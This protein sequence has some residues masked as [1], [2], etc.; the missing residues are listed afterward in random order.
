MFHR[1]HVLRISEGN[2]CFVLPYS[3]SCNNRIIEASQEREEERE[4][5][6]EREGG[7][8]AE[9][10]HLDDWFLT[11]VREDRAAVSFLSDVLC[12]RP[13]FHAPVALGDPQSP[14]PL[15]PPSA[16]TTK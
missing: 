1:A 3:A 8:V 12:S 16:P 6:R 4:R 10:E 9:R 2:T 15:A 7:E 14:P 13:H 5:E 11:Y